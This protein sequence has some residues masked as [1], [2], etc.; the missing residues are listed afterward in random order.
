MKILMMM[1]GYF[2]VLQNTNEIAKVEFTSLARGHHETI[3]ITRDSVNR[4]VNQ[5][6]E[7]LTKKARTIKK[8]EWD[9]I[10]KSLA[11]V[12]IHTI[13]ELP[14]PTMKRSYD[15]ALHS[16]IT[17]TTKSGDQFMHTFD[18]EDPH[19]K[20]KSLMGEIN[21]LRKKSGR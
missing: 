5:R 13:G 3:V 4:S 8:A 7:L 15:G 12:S 16:T 21:A 14:S 11:N 18:D 2:T 1:I 10:I 9:C 19:E 20:L 6:G 17:I